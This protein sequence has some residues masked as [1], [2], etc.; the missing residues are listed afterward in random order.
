MLGFG[1]LALGL[2]LLLGMVVW[3]EVSGYLLDQRQSAAQR[4]GAVDAAALRS[5]LTQG[6]GRPDVPRLLDGLPSTSPSA[7]LLSYR[8]DWYAT[9]PDNG[10]D[11]LPRELRQMVRGGS[12][13]RQRIAVDGQPYLAVGFP[14]MNRGDAFFELYPLADLDKTYRALSITLA[15]AATLTALL[16][17]GVGWFASRRALRPLAGVRAAAAEVARGNLSARV[18]AG[19]DPDLDELATSFNNTASALQ[20]RVVADAR[21]A[22]DVSHE[23]RTPLTTMLNSMQLLQNRRGELP[24]VVREP[25]DLLADELGRFRRLVVDLL[26]ISRHDGGHDN[27]V[28]RVT[29]G[30]LVRQA[31]DTAAG[32][33]VTVVDPD[34][35]GVT[36]LADKR[37]LERVVA[38]LV[39]NADCHGGGCLTVHVQRIPGGARIVV[40]DA[41]PGVDPE[42]RE[43]I[44][45]RFSR[46]GSEGG[47]GVGLGL[48]I[49][50]RH[51]QWHRGTVD[52]VDRPGGGARFVV[53]LPGEG[54]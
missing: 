6:R 7:S 38:N 42:R 14:L 39:E 27:L 54:G 43:R 49:V 36:L 30:D 52:V 2:S 53:D 3:V 10:P 47:R 35:A 13:A 31:G 41:G 4:D 21:F 33:E 26:E 46:D 29:V 45:E 23:L 20:Q 9:S 12:A 11:T 32:R 34:A 51:V 22:G 48:A 1:A 24:P 28:E 16:G 40:D 5:G 8:G 19:Q 17:M 37:R 44:F 18:D 50:A 15:A 25:L